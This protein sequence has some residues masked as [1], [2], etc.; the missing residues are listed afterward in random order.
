MADSRL[1]NLV[2]SGQ[3]AGK[4]FRGKPRIVWNDVVLSDVQK[5][6]M[7]HHNRDARNRPVWR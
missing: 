5:R 4:N 3:A 1:P 7:N 6:K 2:L